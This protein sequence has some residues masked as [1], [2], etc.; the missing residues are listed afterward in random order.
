MSNLRNPNIYKF[1]PLCMY[2]C[3][4]VQVSIK[5]LQS[6]SKYTVYTLCCVIIFNQMFSIILTINLY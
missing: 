4:N 6:T 2:F 3:V 5:M 1:I